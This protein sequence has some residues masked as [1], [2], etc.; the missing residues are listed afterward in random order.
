VIGIL[1]PSQFEY[2]Y[3]RDLKIPAK[4]A[5][6]VCSGM[7][8]IRALEACHH[9]KTRHRNLRHLLLIGFAGSLSEGLKIGDLVEPNVFIEQDYDARP[10]EKFPHV[11]R[12]ENRR[13][14]GSS[15]RGVMVTQDRFLTANPFKGTPLARKYPNLACDMESYAAAFFCE[16]NG[17]KF[18]ALKFIS[19]RA[20]SGAD[21][22]FLSACRKL[23]P[24]LKDATLKAVGKLQIRR[25][26]GR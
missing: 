3:I 11:I 4:K 14:I 7:G 15:R 10:F 6:L 5:D 1:C 2:R 16:A 8:K 23:A 26:W 21:H 9:L 17:V 13:L 18:H 24:L 19:D 20:D 12:V 22:D 25:R